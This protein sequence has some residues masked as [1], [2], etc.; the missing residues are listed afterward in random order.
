VL[1]TAKIGKQRKMKF[2]RINSRSGLHLA[3]LPKSKFSLPKN[4]LNMAQKFWKNVKIAKPL[5]FP[6]VMFGDNLP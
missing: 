1:I 5:S 2:G 4:A 6:S 3:F